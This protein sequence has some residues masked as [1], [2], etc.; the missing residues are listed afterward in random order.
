MLNQLET[1]C[2]VTPGPGPTSTSAPVPPLTQTSE[3]AQT[4]ES[5]IPLETL[6]REAVDALRPQLRRHG[7]DIQFFGMAGDTALIEMKG[8]CVGCALSSVTLA[9][10]RKRICEAVGR[11]LKIAPRSAFVPVGRIRRT[12]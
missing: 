4:R 9:G 10:V 5:S 12:A 1:E 7:G 2:D 8:S 6:V 11:P 3:S